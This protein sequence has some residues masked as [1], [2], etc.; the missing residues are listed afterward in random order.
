LQGQSLDNW[1]SFK[2]LVDNMKK[3][4]LV[5][6]VLLFVSLLGLF[7]APAWAGNTFVVQKVEIEGLQRISP[8]TVYSYLPATQGQSLNASKTAAIIKAL[9]KTGFFEH[10]TLSRSGNKLII[11]VEE[12]PTIGQLKISGNSFI[13]TDKLT[14]V[15]KGLD[16]AEGRVYNRAILE[17]ITQS[18]LNQYYQLGR[19]NAKVNVSV[20]PEERNRVIVKID[21]S[22]GLVARIQRINIIG[23]HAFS[24]HTLEKQLTITTPSLYTFFTQTDRYSEEK[25]GESLES[26]RNY[27]LDRGYIK[28]DVK[29]SQVSITPDRKNVYI[30]L[31]VDEGVPYKVKGYEL[32]GDLILPREE[33]VK[34]IKIKPGQTFSRQ[35]VV[36]T[37]KAISDTLG[38]KGYLYTTVSLSPQVDDTTKQIWLNFQVK[39]GKR[40]YVRH[41]YFSDNSKTN[42]EVLRREMQQME[43]GVVSTAQLDESKRRLRLLPYIR[44]VEMSVKPVPQ[45]DDQ[46]DVNYKVTE[47]NAAALTGS[48][49][50]SQVEHILLGAGVTQKN[51]LG[52]GKTLGVNFQRGRFGQE[53]SVNY[54]D[55]Y[56]TL[57]GIS[58]TI[59]ASV[60]SYDPGALHLTNSYT[61]NEYD[62]SDIY[63]IPIFQEKHAINRL[64]LG[65]GYQNT[66]VNFSAGQPSIEVQNFINT[67]GRRFQQLDLIAG[68][69]RDS[70]DKAIF[71]TNGALQS[72]GVNLFLPLNKKLTYYTFNYSGK[73]YHPIVND[74]LFSAK[75][76]LA[77]GNNFQKGRD[78]PFFKNFYAGGIDSVRGYTDNTLGPEDSNQRPSGGNFL[79]D[80]SVALIVPNYI[81]D[82]LRTSLF[83]DGGNVY[84]TYDNRVTGGT[85][86]GALRYSAGV[87]V[88][89]LT[90]M[91]PVTMS[92]AR[93]L[94][95]NHDKLTMFQFSL[96]ANFG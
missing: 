48:I 12:R 59:S 30:N 19:Y 68:M 90:G 62:V 72:I 35:A 69:S 88:D 29:S 8:E 28:I 61:T 7:I 44:D 57:D 16:I 54:T 78:F 94:N 66:L 42:D 43:S 14:S 26:L 27:Y 83:V 41:I 56:Y 81:S 13:P 53:Y 49:G 86:S 37:E 76:V 5:F 39:P 82:N 50:Y 64:Q 34:L 10:I 11:N 51:F 52:T 84:K 36:D 2:K 75:G 25:L 32:T 45:S 87:A 67:Y 91:G 58:R 47:D 55:P 6:A 71:P 95:A 77:Y 31:V 60:S 70:R 4:I 15:M 33:L 20:T 9:Y 79:L 17:R 3:I 96:G 74:F 18:L 40:T 38:N 65:Y 1:Q 63:A 24:N 89:W 46:V 21:I 85:A 22:E 80:G 92:L 93:A 73:W 23:N